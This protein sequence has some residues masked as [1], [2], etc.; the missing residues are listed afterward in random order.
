MGET[1]LSGLQE[2][3]GDN[4]IWDQTAD[5][6]V[7]AWLPGSRGIGVAD[8]LYGEYEFKGK[9]PH[10]W[11]ASFDQIS[12]NVDKQPDEPGVDTKDATLLYPYGYGPAY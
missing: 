9:L 4:V 2:L 10:T 7:A 11:P 8:V 1:I 5:A 12:V 3:G 6:I